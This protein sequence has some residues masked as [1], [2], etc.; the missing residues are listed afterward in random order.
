M[1]VLLINGSPRPRG[2]TYTALKE[3]EKTLNEAGVETE[4]FHI[5]AKAIQG[6]TDCGA[7]AGGKPCV[8]GGA[9]DGR[10]LQRTVQPDDVVD[11]GVK[12]NGI[13]HTSVSFTNVCCLYLEFGQRLVRIAPPCRSVMTAG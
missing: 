12:C 1:K 2:C 6:C 11:G 8:A 9:V 13:D 5:G 4:I 7:C 10:D 3:T